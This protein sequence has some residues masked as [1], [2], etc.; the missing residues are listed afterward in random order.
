MILLPLIPFEKVIPFN[1]PF[2]T[3]SSENVFAPAIV[4]APLV[5]MPPLVASAGLSVKVVPLIVAPF[6]LEVPL[7]DPTALTPAAGKL[8]ELAAVILPFASTVNVGIA[9]EEP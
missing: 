9:D 1:F 5:T 8:A 4:C 2:N 6:T 7:I 3:I